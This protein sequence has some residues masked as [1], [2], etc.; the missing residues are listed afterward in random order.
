MG[1]CATM[2]GQHWMKRVIVDI[3]MM[4]KRLMPMTLQTNNKD[5]CIYMILPDSLIYKM[6]LQNVKQVNVKQF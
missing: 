6:L 5:E 3:A 4:L 2:Q 1:A